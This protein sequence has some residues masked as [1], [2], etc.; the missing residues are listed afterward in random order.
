MLTFYPGCWQAFCRFAMS[1]KIKNELKQ[2]A[3]FEPI[4]VVTA[5]FM[6]KPSQARSMGMAFNY[7]FA[8]FAGLNINLINFGLAYA[9]YVCRSWILSIYLL[10]VDSQVHPLSHALAVRIVVLPSNFSKSNNS[11][12]PCS[13]SVTV[14]CGERSVNQ[15]AVAL[16]YHRGHTRL[17]HYHAVQ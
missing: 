16:L 12:D 1:T 2:V 17:L 13:L 9:L 15:M 4:C 6:S 10:K 3:D 7:R 5:N 14:Y 8:L 11:A